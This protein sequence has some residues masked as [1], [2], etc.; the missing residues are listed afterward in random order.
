M[1]LKEVTLPYDPMPKQQEAHGLSA[2]Y[3]G[4][5]GGW[6]NGKT[7]WGCAETFILLHE[8]PGTNCIIARKTRPELKSTTWDMFLHGDP[9]APGAWEGVP[10]ETIKSYNKSDMVIEFHNGSVV[11]G[12]P[13]DDPKKIENYNLGL[14]WIDQA[15]EIEEDIFLKF[16]GR[17]RQR[18]GPREGLLTF[19]P[20][21]HNWL[22]SRFIDEDRLDKWQKLYR[23]VE[24]TTYD[25]PNLPDDYLDQFEGLPDAWIQRF[26]MGSH[27]VFVG[28]IFTDWNPETHVIQPFKIPNDWERWQVTDPG[29]RHE[30]AI[31]WVARDS[32]GNAYYYREHL[33]AN[34]PVEWWAGKILEMESAKDFGGPDE[35]ITRRLIGPEA[36]QRS[37]TDGKSVLDLFF[38][39]GIYPEIADRDPSAR[40]SVITQYLRPRDDRRNP[41]SGT[42]PAPKLYV[43]STCSKLLQY[44][45]Q[46]RW[47]P[48]RTNFAEEDSP[49]KPRKKDDHNIDNLGHLLLAFDQLPPVEGSGPILTPEQRMVADEL[50]AAYEQALGESDD[51]LTHHLLGAD[52]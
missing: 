33:T 10:R 43:F 48:Q 32:V 35:Q 37:Q 27:E 21:G 42:S 26:V 12:L 18:M 2:K 41:F 23:C 51:S 30:G 52:Y 49:E 19:N 47:R 34:Q 17:L 4:F 16:Q 14:Y 5:C 50:E 11:H 9:G 3:R 25:N 31:S 38:E 22:W 1:K 45:P 36:R 24:A 46:Y 28:Q 20:N 29:I 8:F 39:H 6:G 40:I 15:E 13:L 7:S 44:L